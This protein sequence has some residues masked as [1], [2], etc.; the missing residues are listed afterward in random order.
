MHYFKFNI[1]DYH[2]ATRHFN[3]IEHGAY[4]HLMTLFYETEKP[5]PKSI[6]ELAKLCMTRS[7]EEINAIKRILENFF[8]ETEDGYVQKRAATE[9]EKYKSNNGKKAMASNIR[10]DK[11]RKEKAEEKQ[12]EVTE[13]ETT[14]VHIS[15]PMDVNISVWEDYMHFRKLQKKPLYE[16]TLKSIRKEA[17]QAGINLNQAITVCLENNWINFKAQW[18]E[19][20]KAKSKQ[21]EPMRLPGK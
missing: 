7:E 8:V 21:N 2:Y 16:T 20:L 4:L 13:E 6:D 10:W 19:E 9:L 18:Y 17:V 12:D 15:K 5:L 3:F 14:L 11:Y 1:K